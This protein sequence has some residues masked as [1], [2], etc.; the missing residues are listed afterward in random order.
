MFD[1]LKLRISGK[2]ILT[3]MVN[4]K[5]FWLLNFP[6]FG[7]MGNILHTWTLWD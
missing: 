6:A 3:R 7:V 1:L 2:K 5:S 4:W